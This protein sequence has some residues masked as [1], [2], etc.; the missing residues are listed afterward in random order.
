MVE[1][2]WIKCSPSMGKRE[3]VCRNAI[4]RIFRLSTVYVAE[5]RAVRSVDAEAMA[6]RF[7]LKAKKK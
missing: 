4:H 6:I 2:C 1:S 5:G 7:D 3:Y